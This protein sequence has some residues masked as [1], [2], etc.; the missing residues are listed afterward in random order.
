ERE[1]DGEAQEAVPMARGL[2]AKLY[3]A[4]D[5]WNAHIWT[6]SANATTAALERN[7]E[8]LVQ[9]TGK[10]SRVGIDRVLG[11]EDKNGL[12]TLLTPFVPAE[13][14]RGPSAAELKLEQ[15]LL[16]GRRTVA[17]TS[18]VMRIE[19]TTTSG[20]ELFDATLHARGDGLLL[21]AGVEVR[22]WPISLNEGY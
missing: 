4:E 8:F 22:C 19:P 20:A 13:G 18:W 6:G 2:H 12:H 11:Y 14:A 16:A 1:E 10:K 3:V 15:K 5:G 7:V 17:R 9:L 21:P